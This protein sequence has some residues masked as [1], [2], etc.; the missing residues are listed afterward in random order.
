MRLLINLHADNPNG[1]L[2]ERRRCAI[3]EPAHQS[4]WVANNKPPSVGE[5]HPPHELPERYPILVRVCSKVISAKSISDKD[6]M[7]NA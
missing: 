5:C 2:R 4:I 3:H 6:M 7:V 1:I